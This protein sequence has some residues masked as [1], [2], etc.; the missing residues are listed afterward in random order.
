VP[1][2]QRGHIAMVGRT[3]YLPPLLR[4]LPG[5]DHCSS[6]EYLFLF[7]TFF[8]PLLLSLNEDINKSVITA[9]V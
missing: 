2:G 6:E 7:V 4:D 3:V 1:L 5:T 8:R 9:T